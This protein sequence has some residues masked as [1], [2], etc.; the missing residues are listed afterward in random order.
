MTIKGLY[1]REKAG[2]VPQDLCGARQILL[3]LAEMNP[4]K[5]E[6]VEYHTISLIPAYV[7]RPRILILSD[8]TWLW[9]HPK[10]KPTVDKRAEAE[11]DARNYRKFLAGEN[12]EKDDDTLYPSIEREKAIREL[13]EKNAFLFYDNS[14][15]ILSDSRLFLVQTYSSF[16]MCPVGIQDIPLGAFVEFWRYF[17]RGQKAR[18]WEGER[19]IELSREDGEYIAGKDSLITSASG[20]LGGA[21][22]CTEVFRDGHVKYPSFR[23][24]NEVWQV[25]WTLKARYRNERLEECKAYTIEEAIEILKGGDDRHQA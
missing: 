1:K 4:Q 8:G 18:Y 11:K 25:M 12:F 19:R 20:S 16:G 23:S 6:K 2:N 13:F 24:Y 17:H 14:D 3:R 22:T 10:D 7:A 21:H 5:G 9:L 15:R